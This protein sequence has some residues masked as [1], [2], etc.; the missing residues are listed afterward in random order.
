MN[1]GC[2]GP[3]ARSFSGQANQ[4]VEVDISSMIEPRVGTPGATYLSVVA[5]TSSAATDHFV[6]LRFAYSTAE[7]P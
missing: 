1:G 7:A 3:F 6:G 5:Y 2:A 4:L